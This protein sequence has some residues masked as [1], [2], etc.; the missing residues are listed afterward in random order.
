MYKI[1]QLLLCTFFLSC[2]QPSISTM[3]INLDYS[4]TPHLEQWGKDAQQLLLEWIPKIGESLGVDKL[5]NEINLVL[6]NSDEGI[7]YADS[8]K[9]VVSSH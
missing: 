2:N 9:I 8:N 1:I 4:E 7:A 3:K 6:Q 5:P